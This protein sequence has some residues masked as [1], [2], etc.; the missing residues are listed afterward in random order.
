M[1]TVAHH[2]I[3]PSLRRQTRELFTAKTRETAVVARRQTTAVF[4]RQELALLPRLMSWIFN[5][6]ASKKNII[7]KVDAPVEGL[8]AMG[9]EIQ[10]QRAL[11]VLVE[12]AIIFSPPGSTIVVGARRSS[13]SVRFWVDDQGPGVLPATTPNARPQRSIRFLTEAESE[14]QGLALCGRIIA[15]HHGAIAVW[16]RVEGGTRFEF[17]I[18]SIVRHVAHV[19]AHVA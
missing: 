2:S 10:L 13:D 3:F 18:P 8:L 15:T 5:D 17:S 14:P 12:N 11:E 16:E 1:Q 4:D 9:D 6:A 7:L 19:N